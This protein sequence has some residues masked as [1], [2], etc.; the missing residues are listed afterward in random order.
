MST[1][2]DDLL[3]LARADQSEEALPTCPVDLD[4]LVAEC[5]GEAGYGGFVLDGGFHSVYA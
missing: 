1:L 4:E 3:M 2:V 5:L